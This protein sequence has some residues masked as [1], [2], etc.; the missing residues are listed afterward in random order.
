LPMK[1][2]PSLSLTPIQD[3]EQQCPHQQE[4]TRDAWF[5]AHLFKHR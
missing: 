5:N 4:V 2:K 1:I 3:D